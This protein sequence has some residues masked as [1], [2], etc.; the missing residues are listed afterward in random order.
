[1]Q[2]LFIVLLSVICSILFIYI[3]Y[4]NKSTKSK[5]KQKY[6]EEIKLELQTVEAQERAR[7]TAELCAEEEKTNAAIQKVREWHDTQKLLLEE[8]IE[9]LRI[10]TADVIDREKEVINAV[11][12]E[13]EEKA[14][15]ES[16]LRIDKEVAEAAAR[17]TAAMQE[18]SKAFEDE[19]V[20]LEAEKALTVTELNKLK[21]ALAALNEDALRRL[22]LEEHEDFYRVCLSETEKADLELL[23]SIK[24]RLHIHDKF[25]KLIYDVYVSKAVTEMTRRVL[26]G[27][28]PSGIYKITRLKTG[29]VYIGKST[30]VK[31]R[32]TEHCKTTYNV[33]T[34][35]HSILHTTMKKDGIDG[36]TFEL[37]EKVSKD[38]LTEREKY[39][40]EFYDSKKLGLNE[41]NG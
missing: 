23:N 11:T 4:N 17:A 19:R 33:G 16:K 21:D 25:D 8:Q 3:I 37:L 29:Q 39:W 14:K 31:K 38:Q 7:L 1:M 32:W 10:H 2:L 13:Y 34:I 18:L 12:A 26:E 15:I 20:R 9:S 24:D 40:I 36:F 28:A 30:D 35:A 22:Q 27:E 6:Y 41:R 5:L